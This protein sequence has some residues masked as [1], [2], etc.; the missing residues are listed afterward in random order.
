M[1]RLRRW[2]PSATCAAARL[3]RAFVRQGLKIMA[4][5]R[6]VGLRALID[7]AAINE[8][9]AHSIWDLC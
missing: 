3:N 8:A 6:N 2:E 1:A 5:R 7:K 4:Q 9:P